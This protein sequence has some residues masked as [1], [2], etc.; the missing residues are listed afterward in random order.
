MIAEGTGSAQTVCCFATCGTE[1]CPGP[2][3]KAEVSGCK[4]CS[5]RTNS[6]GGTWHSTSV[7]T[8][9]NPFRKDQAAERDAAM[10]MLF[11]KVALVAGRLGAGVAVPWGL[12]I[13]RV[14]CAGSLAGMSMVT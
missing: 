13:L 1:A 11:F 14:T 2:S 9:T 8:V 4:W 10:P 6:T 12:G 3:V 7:A 5:R